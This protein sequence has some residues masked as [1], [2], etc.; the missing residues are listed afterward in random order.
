[1][2]PSVFINML[3]KAYSSQFNPEQVIKGSGLSE[4]KK[5]VAL[6]ILDAY[7]SSGAMKSGGKL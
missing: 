4:E 6:E 3:N 1:M 7:I 2:V 5:N